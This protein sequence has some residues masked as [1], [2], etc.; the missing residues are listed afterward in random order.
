VG[1][2]VNDEALGIHFSTIS[3]LTF[4]IPPMFYIP[5][6]NASFPVGVLPVVCIHYFFRVCPL[7]SLIPSLLYIN[8]YPANVEN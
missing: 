1:F 5:S 6:L 4:T 8:P 7:P 3:V 2:L